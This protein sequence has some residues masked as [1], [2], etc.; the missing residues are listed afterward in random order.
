[1][2]LKTQVQF[3]NLQFEESRRV[4]LF[5]FELCSQLEVGDLTDLFRGR[6][7]EELVYFHFCQGQGSKPH[8]SI[9]PQTQNLQRSITL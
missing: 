9:F 2:I 4:A 8:S 5:S 3:Y 1:M 7:S 6:A